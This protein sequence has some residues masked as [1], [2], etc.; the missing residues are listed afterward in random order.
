MRIEL[1]LPDLP[2][3]AVGYEVVGVVE[4]RPLDYM[5]EEVDGKL[6]WVI[7]DYKPHGMKIVARK[8]KPTGLDFIESLEPGT[9]IDCG[10]FRYV[11]LVDKVRYIDGFSVALVVAHVGKKGKWKWSSKTSSLYLANPSA[12]TC[13]IYQPPEEDE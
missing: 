6:K 11:R 13:T 3:E 8:R 5:I 12:D 9:V 10:K 4:S 2:E 1:N 7:I